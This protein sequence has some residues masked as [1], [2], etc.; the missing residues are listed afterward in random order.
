MRAPHL[1]I[2]LRKKPLI[3]GSVLLL[4][5]AALGV[6][7][8]QSDQQP[9]NKATKSGSV[10]AQTYNLTH[11][12]DISDAIVLA[13]TE[14]VDGPRWD[15]PTGEKPA[16]VASE[17]IHGIHRVATFDIRETWKGDITDT[18][19][20]EIPGGEVDGYGLQ[21][22][23]TP[24]VSDGE[25]AVLFLREHPDTG[26]LHLWSYGKY[27]VEDGTIQTRDAGPT[28]SQRY[29]LDEVEEIATRTHK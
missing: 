15:T 24:S 3:I 11:L 16:E 18:L 14:T 25:T 6:Y 9:I 22:F 12:A 5:I 23:V 28:P 17:D 20:L 27:V 21:S 13:T 8:Q 2:S 4:S 19:T 7:H 29:T 26:E 1:S 10:A